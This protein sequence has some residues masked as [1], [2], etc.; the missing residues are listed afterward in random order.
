MKSLR[1]EQETKITQFLRDDKY[2]SL[3]VAVSTAKCSSPVKTSLSLSPRKTK[4]I[5]K[6]KPFRL[7]L[8]S[9]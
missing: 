8:E 9:D 7:I 4:R 6:V 1:E 3:R 2:K 5:D